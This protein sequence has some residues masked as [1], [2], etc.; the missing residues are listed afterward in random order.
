MGGEVELSLSSLVTLPPPPPK[1]S[2]PILLSL[3][4]PLGSECFGLEQAIFPPLVSLFL[5]DW[6]SV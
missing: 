3:L 4:N 2:C 1:V 5:G 6:A